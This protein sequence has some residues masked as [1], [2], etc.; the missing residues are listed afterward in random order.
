[1]RERMKFFAKII[2]SFLIA[3]PAVIFANQDKLD[4]TAAT[5]MQIARIQQELKKIVPDSFLQS[6]QATS[7]T[8]KKNNQTYRTIDNI[9]EKDG[10]FYPRTVKEVQTLILFAKENHFQ[11]R[12]MGAGH[13]AGPAIFNPQNVRELHVILDG[14]FINSIKFEIDSSKK[15]AIVTTGAG[16]HLGVDPTDPRSTWGNSFN[17]IVDQYGYALPTLGGISHQTIAGFLQTSSSGGSAQH[18]IADVIE[19]IEWVDGN[20]ILHH[21][22]KGEDEFNAVVVS[23]GMF[24]IITQVTFKLPQK[25]LVEGTDT[26]HELQDSLIVKDANG[27]YTKLHDA[28]FTQYEYAHIN[29]LPQK[30]VNRTMQWVGKSVP[31][32]ESLPIVPYKHALSSSIMANLAV[33]VFRAAN[34]IDEYGSS[35]DILL[36]MK[37]ELFKP[38]A[39]PSDKQE[40][41]DVWYKA[42]PIDDQA[43]VDGLVKTIFSEMWFPEDQIDTV[44]QKLEEL[45]NENPKAAGNFIVE[46]YAAKASPIWLSPAYGHHAFRVDL[47][48][49][50]GNR[51][52]SNQ[53]FGLFWEKLLDIPGARLHWGKYLPLP[54]VKYGEKIFTSEQLYRNYP[55]FNEWLALREK[56]D[57]QQMFVTDYWRQILDIPLVQGN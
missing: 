13:S 16:I 33:M 57:P 40:F 11:V 21:A 12:V 49:W 45:F 3:I 22:N 48:W 37:A 24:G 2:L 47:Y 9:P 17:Y 27:H 5:K 7:V 55:K 38:F 51:G 42:L 54:G 34:L 36:R 35:S 46:L 6:K 26:N 20:G 4:Q 41:R 43:D 1:M 39:K 50:T 28:L 30:Y 25:Y 52:D 15:F 31:Y 8:V 23:M 44:M 18:G 53:Y 14:E 29:W 10:I 19:A 56:M 32:D